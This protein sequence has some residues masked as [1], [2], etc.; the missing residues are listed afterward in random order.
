[1]LALL[2]SY[3]VIFFFIVPSR[4]FRISALFLK[5]KKFQRTR[6]EEITFAF[7]FAI[8]PFSIAAAVS[9]FLEARG[10]LVS[11]RHYQEIFNAAYSEEYFRNSVPQFW[12]SLSDIV[13]AQSLFLVAYYLLCLL[14]VF[15]FVE[16]VK[17]WGDWHE[18]HRFYKWFAEKLL[19]NISEWDM[20]LTPF[21]FPRNE[22][23]IVVCD[24][25]TVEDHLYQGI[26]R[27]Y[28]LSLEG[29]LT[30]VFFKPAYR[31]NRQGYTAK[32]LGDASTRAEDFWVRVPG[33]NLYVPKDKI[34]NLNVW[35]PPE[36]AVKLPGA[37]TPDT[38]SAAATMQLAKEKLPYR[39]VPANKDNGE[40]GD[41]TAP[42]ETL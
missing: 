3:F 24:A 25:L 30:G 9:L 8:V 26:V 15:L 42:K 40:G 10:T 38:E 11:W 29:E 39:V 2:A 5:L 27:D 20:L 23:R 17:K 13:V 41:P 12:S 31:F 18:R 36:D 28:Y 14:E 21:N 33:D 35:Y 32:K 6:T 22:K 19:R 4:I 1:M 7:L 37:A 16:L 34:L